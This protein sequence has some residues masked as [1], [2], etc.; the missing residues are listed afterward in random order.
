MTARAGA[1]AGIAAPLLFGVVVA[2]LTV[3]E[4][5]FATDLGWDPVRRTHVGWPSVLALGEDGWVLTAALA[6]CGALGLAFAAGLA[7]AVRRTAW[8][9]LGIAMLAIFSAGVGL[10]SFTTDPPGSLARATW[11]G[12]VHDRV[13][14]VVVVSAVAA[15]VFLGLAFA[16]DSQWRILAVPTLATA[17]ILITALV[18][19]IERRYAQLLEYPFFATLLVW[20]EL[21]AMRLWRASR[22][23]DP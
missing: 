10:E 4:Y 22:A 11:H 8:S 13:Y 1:L 21:V 3:A 9:T 2:A 5:D 16:H 18:L 17:V 7:G 23:P 14:P 12:E 20:L 19:Q 15:P 6:C